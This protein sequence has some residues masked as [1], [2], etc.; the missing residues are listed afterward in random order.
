[1]GLFKKK[2]KNDYIDTPNGKKE[3]YIPEDKK[4]NG[5]SVERDVIQEVAIFMNQ[6]GI[7]KNPG[8]KFFRNDQGIFEGIYT[9]RIND[10]SFSM[11]KQTYGPDMYLMLLGSHALGAGIYVAL[12]QSK[13]KKPVEEFQEREMFEMASNMHETDVY[14]LALKTIGFAPDSGNKKCLDGIVQTGVFTYKMSCGE[15]AFDDNNI[16]ILMQ[17]LY[18]AGITV[19][20][21]C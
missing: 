2:K 18:N 20:L 19:V 13:Y 17:V 12:C 14:E 9:G 21:G 8:L 10:P 4:F 7:T 16:K 6:I 1:M 5:S 11:I 3:I 15:A